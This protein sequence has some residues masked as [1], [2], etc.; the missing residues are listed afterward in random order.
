MAVV[1][2]DRQDYKD[3]LPDVCMRCG[4]DAPARKWKT[5][6]WHPGWVYLL[7]LIHLLIF[8]IAALILTKRCKV[9][10]PLCEQ[11]RNHWFWRQLITLGGLFGLI[12]LII[13]AAVN[14][15]AFGQDAGLMIFLGS[16]AGFVAWLIVAVVL[17]VGSIRVTTIR[18]RSLTLTNVSR[19]FVRAYHDEIDRREEA[20]DRL[21]R[22]RWERRRR[23]RREERDEKYYRRDEDEP[24]RPRRPRDEF[25]EG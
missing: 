20:M 25:R 22:E 1:E 14:S 16:V 7:I 15:D 18:D 17:Q 19:E 13:V 2:L 21:A 23:P 9:A 8:I 10:V 4:A 24:E 5:F 6:S 11:H 3:G 12:G